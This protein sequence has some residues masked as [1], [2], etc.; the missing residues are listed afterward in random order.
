MGF[1]TVPECSLASDIPQMPQN[2]YRVRVMAGYSPPE[3][4]EA[5][6]IDR[7]RLV[8]AEAGGSPLP[9][10]EWKHVL[11]VCGRRAFDYERR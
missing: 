1:S 11:D 9:D 2:I 7:V 6:G 10:S 5:A 8:T 4:A 3:L